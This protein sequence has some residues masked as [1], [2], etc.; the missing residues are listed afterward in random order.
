MF[1]VTFGMTLIGCSENEKTSDGKTEIMLKLSPSSLVLT[2]GEEVTLSISILPENIDIVGVVWNSDNINVATVNESGLINALA[3]GEAIITVQLNGA[4][5]SSTI[6]VV[7]KENDNEKP[8]PH[9]LLEYIDNVAYIDLDKVLTYEDLNNA[10]KKVDKDNITSYA[11]RGNLG[12]KKELSKVKFEKFSPSVFR[13]TNVELIDFSKVTG[14]EPV[15][16]D[17]YSRNKLSIGIGLPDNWFSYKESIGDHALCPNLRIVILPSTIEAIGTEA[18]KGCPSL[19]QVMM[20]GVKEIGYG[21]FNGCRKLSYLTTSNIEYLSNYV[22]S[23]CAA[24]SSLNLP[25]VINIPVSA[26]SNCKSLATIYLPEAK[27]IGMSA[28][29]GYTSLI[30]LD[31]PKVETISEFGINT[32]TI[33]TLN[34]PSVTKLEYRSIS[35]L[36]GAV[37]KLTTSKNIDVYREIDGQ[38]KYLKTPF[39]EMST[40]KCTIYLHKNKKNGGTGKPTVSNLGGKVTWAGEEWKEIVYADL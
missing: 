17:E 3:E 8:L 39:S 13:N 25:K 5:A 32:Y 19:E 20:E 38:H 33:K 7:K 4:F 40:E 16:I 18:F 31:L 37:L 30:T 6:K 36:S 15:Y 9:G 24:L 2:E 21:A 28:F 14:W 11:F 12:A 34:L 35:S 23:D 27:Y 1:L 22:F 29:S 26:F 10:I